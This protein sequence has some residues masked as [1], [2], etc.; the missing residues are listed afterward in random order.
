LTVDIE[1]KL[2]T[3]FRIV[4][5]EIIGLGA[6]SLLLGVLQLYELGG[7]SRIADFAW[8]FVLIGITLVLV[9]FETQSLLRRSNLKE[10]N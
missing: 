10:A 1:L 6:F 5:V 8:T 7:D 3:R 9:G 2:L 4:F